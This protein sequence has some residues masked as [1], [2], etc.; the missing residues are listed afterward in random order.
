MVSS[1]SRCKMYNC[2]YLLIS[3]DTITTY[4][5]DKNR[6]SYDM[7][8]IGNTK[9]SRTTIVQNNSIDIQSGAESD[10]CNA[11]DTSA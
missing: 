5:H 2:K 11:T 7:Y 9:N 1:L 6:N 8:M 4:I 3:K 10:N